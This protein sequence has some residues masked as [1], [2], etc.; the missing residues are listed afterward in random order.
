M[1]IR[2]GNTSRFVLLN[3]DHLCKKCIILVWY[4]SFSLIQII[5]WHCHGD[6]FANKTSHPAPVK[7]RNKNDVPLVSIS[8][9][10][11][12]TWLHRHDTFQPTSITDPHSAPHS[13][14]CFWI[15]LTVNI[16]FYSPKPKILSFHLKITSDDSWKSLDFSIY[17]LAAITMQWIFSWST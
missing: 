14:A 5:P 16:L 10:T 6:Y 8:T 9:L 4:L 11:L 15:N 2:S 17:V 13:L 3:L 12:T 1:Q 7:K